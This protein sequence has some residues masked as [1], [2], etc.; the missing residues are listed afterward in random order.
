MDRLGSMPIHQ[1]VEQGFADVVR[2]LLDKGS[3]VAV[4][5]MHGYTALH[6]SYERFLHDAGATKRGCTCECYHTVGVHVLWCLHTS[7]NTRIPFSW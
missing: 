6:V 7:S 4:P 5:D 3:E 2:K 1:A